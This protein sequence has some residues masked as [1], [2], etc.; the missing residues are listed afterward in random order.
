MALV[1]HVENGITLTLKGN[2]AVPRTS[3]TFFKP[4]MKVNRSETYC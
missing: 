1:N 3:G 2:H 4:K